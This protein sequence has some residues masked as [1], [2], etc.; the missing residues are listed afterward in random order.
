MVEAD[1][2]LQRIEHAGYTRYVLERNPRRYNEYGEELE[3]SETDD[4]A[5]AD[6]A[7]QNAYSG[8]RLEGTTLCP[9]TPPHIR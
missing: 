7:D 9:A 5:D 2:S 8:I 1:P 6:A 4:E 3:D